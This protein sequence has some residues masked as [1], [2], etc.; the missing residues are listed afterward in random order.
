MKTTIFLLSLL[1][2][3][4]AMAQDTLQNKVL[5][6]AQAHE[7]I[8]LYVRLLKETHPGL[9]RYNT[10]A[11]IEQLI[12]SLKSSCDDSVPFY[13][14]YQKVALL[15]A[16]INCSHSY[17]IPTANLQKYMLSVKSIPFYVIPVRDR[18][19]VLFNGTT[20]ESIKPGDEILSINGM[21]IITIMNKIRANFWTDGKI[22]LSKNVALQGRLFRTFYY[23]LVDQSD[24]LEITFR[25]KEGQEV[26]QTVPAASTLT[27]MRNYR[28]NPVNAEIMS[29]YKKQNRKWNV[30]YP[31]DL[32][33]TA[34][35]TIPGFGGKKIQ[36]EDAAKAYVEQF[37]DKAMKAIKKKNIQHLVFEFRYNSGGWDIMG[38]TLISYLLQD[39]D[40][41]AYY[42]PGYAATNQSEFLKYSDIS[43]YELDNLSKVLE[44]MPDGS[45]KLKEEFNASHG[46]VQKRANAFEGNVFILM[47]E[48]TGSAAVEFCAIMKSNKLA[49][50][51][52]QET[53]GTYG[54]LNGSTFIDM[55]LPNSG[56]KVHTP[57]VRG[58]MK[59]EP[60]Q[61]MDRGVLP[62]HDVALE[63][64]DILMRRDRQFEKVKELILE[65]NNS[66]E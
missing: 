15:N 6:R 41:I 12:D 22:E 32:P 61:P 56:I 29:F 66:S 9:Y 54:G 11:N 4:A 26:T 59:V 49:T 18:L 45:Y 55:V 63:I 23:S 42:G 38:T 57:L 44:P 36:D 40:S 2:S 35:V 64:E 5:S 8:D 58:Y 60:V 20:S 21:P 24:Q 31:E 52:G 17:A 34:V 10:P 1:A 14:L 16:R 48:Y 33:S 7:D 25:T 39:Q 50:L 62:D 51:I 28:K 47:D 43:Q 53:N 30:K 13:E 27:A 46:M 65:Q 3:I 37:M 19:Y